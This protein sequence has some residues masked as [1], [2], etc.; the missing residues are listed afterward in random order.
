MVV[1]P[2]GLLGV[3][4]GAREVAVEEAGGDLVGQNGRDGAGPDVVLLA[5]GVVGRVED[6]PRRDLRLIDRRHRLRAP[7]KAGEHPGE[8]RSIDGRHLREGD[9]HL[10]ALMHQLGAHRGREAVD[11]VLGAAIDGLQRDGARTESRTHLHDRATVLRQHAGERSPCAVDEAQVGDL[12]GARVLLGSD[13]G[14]RREDRTEGAVDPH[15]DAPEGL[16][17]GVGGGFGLLVVGHVGGQDESAAAGLLDITG[18]GVQPGPAAGEKDD[19]GASG[20][21]RPGGRPADARARPGDDNSL[22]HAISPQSLGAAVSREAVSSIRACTKAC[23]RLPR[24]WRCPMSYS[25]V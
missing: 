4:A 12:G 14:E 9:A 18:G 17:R 20:G 15:V 3:V 1:G 24:N 22:G 23:G 2:V 16:D 7:G 13:L 25:S 11:G 21:E 6:G 5:S 8:L 19:V 10:T